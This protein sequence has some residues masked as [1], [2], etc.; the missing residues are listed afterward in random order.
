MNEWKEAPA[1]RHLPAWKMAGVSSS[2][3]LST[4]PRV[5]S[6]RSTSATAPAPRVRSSST[7]ASTGEPAGALEDAGATPT[8]LPRSRSHEVVAQ[9]EIDSHT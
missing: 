1:I 6:V 2:E 7:K 9:V 4:R 5:D 8:K 3:P